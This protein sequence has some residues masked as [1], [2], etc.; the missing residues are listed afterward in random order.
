MIEFRS[1][2][3]LFSGM[4]DEWYDMVVKGIHFMQSDANLKF[5]GVLRRTYIGLFFFFFFFWIYWLTSD[6]NPFL[7]NRDHTYQLQSTKAYMF[8]CFDRLFVCLFLNCRITVAKYIWKTVLTLTLTLFC[9]CFQS[10]L[11]NNNK[12]SFNVFTVIVWCQ[13]DMIDT[14]TFSIKF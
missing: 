1:W 7:W 8:I 13:A 9:C 6:F 5:T 11:K 14:H 3:Y 10:I 2:L 12:K 4:M